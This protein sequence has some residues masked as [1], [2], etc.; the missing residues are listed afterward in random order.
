MDGDLGI[1]RM[2]FDNASEGNREYAIESAAYRGHADIVRFLLSR[3]VSCHHLSMSMVLYA[4]D[5]ETVRLV[6]G[7]GVRFDRECLPIAACLGHAALV[8][9]ILSDCVSSR[10]S[11]TNDILASNLTRDVVLVA[12]PNHMVDRAGVVGVLADHVLSDG[13]PPRSLLT[14]V[15]VSAAQGGHVDLVMDMIARGA[16]IDA[17]LD[18]NRTHDVPGV[19]SAIRAAY[20]NHAVDYA[21]LLSMSTSGTVPGTVEYVFSILPKGY[22]ID[23]DAMARESVAAHRLENLSVILEHGTRAGHRFDYKYIQELP[24]TRDIV[25]LIH[26]YRD[27]NVE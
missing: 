15:A 23:Y 22:K 25:D 17:V 24:G 13:E 2:L 8:D 27:A 19:V 18:S 4:R 20:P 11:V 10:S 16:D 14:E 26:R 7:A 1:V 5:M 12:L 3:G 6:H 9:H 21:E